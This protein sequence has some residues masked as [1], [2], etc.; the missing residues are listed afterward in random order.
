M[1]HSFFHWTLTPWAI[2]GVAGLALAYAGFRKGARQP[3]E[4]GVRAADRG[5]QGGVLAGQG[6]RSARGVRHGLRHGDQPRPGCAAGRGGP[7]HH[8]RGDARPDDGADRHRVAV[9]GVRGVG[10]LRAAPGREVAVDAEH[11]PGGPADGV[12]VPG[13]SDG[14]R[15]GLDPASIGGYLQNLLPMA[16]RTG[17]FSDP[18]WLGAWTIFYWAWW[19]SWAPFVGTFIARISHGRTIREFLIEGC[20]WCPAAPRSSGSR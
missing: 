8:R 20:C 17:A 2:Y 18:E 1:E 11:R 14:V 4:R 5:A 16:T 6:H 15:A 10:V 19:L 13:G 7:R 12:R 3:A 9:R